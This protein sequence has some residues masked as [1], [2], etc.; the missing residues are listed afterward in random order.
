MEIRSVASSSRD[1]RAAAEEIAAGLSDLAPDLVFAFLSH[2]HGPEFSEVTE[3]LSEA[4]PA[5]SFVGCTA[6]SVIGP[7]REIEE[8][9][10]LSVWAAN[11][12]GVESRSFHLKQEDLESIETPEAFRDRIGI[13]PEKNPGFIVLPDPY[14]IDVDRFL[15]RMDEAYP[16][17]V[18]VGGAAS[19]GAQPGENRLFLDDATTEG[20]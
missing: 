11:L 9:P 5:A 2:H 3:V 7:D 12:P 19:G 17:A 15:K 14:T 8:G 13:G 1:S 6:E 16:G 4:F 20:A 10:G 18:L